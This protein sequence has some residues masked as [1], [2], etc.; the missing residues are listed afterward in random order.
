MLAANDQSPYTFERFLPVMGP[1]AGAKPFNN[2]K[3][4][5]IYIYYTLT[6]TDPKQQIWGISG[7][8]GGLE[9]EGPESGGL[10]SNLKSEIWNLK[11][12]I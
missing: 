3:Y 4:I 1:A 10:E 8:L 2:T 12:E 5:Y 7:G 6:A 11:S 9:S